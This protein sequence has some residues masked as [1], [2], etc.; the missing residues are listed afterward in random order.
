MQ[1]PA[2]LVLQIQRLNFLASETVLKSNEHVTFPEIL[3][4]RDHVFYRNRSVDYQQSQSMRMLGGGQSKVRILEWIIFL[5]KNTIKNVSKNFFIVK[6]LKLILINQNE[7]FSIEQFFS[8]N[9]VSF[10]GSK[11]AITPSLNLYL[12]NSYFK[13]ENEL[14]I[15]HCVNVA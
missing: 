7:K 5:Y 2:C 3:D 1:L 14:R 12:I 6:F 15:R 13:N 10:V 9:S 8:Q 4:V 11:L